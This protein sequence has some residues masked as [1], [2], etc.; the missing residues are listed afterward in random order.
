MRRRLAFF[1][2]VAGIV[3]LAGPA[4]SGGL[5]TCRLKYDLKGWS[6]IYRTSK[7]SG[8]ITCENGQSSKV[9][10]STRRVRWRPQAVREFIE[11]REES[12]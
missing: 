4:S 7:G 9:R 2:A 5:M 12:P 1:L 11:Q 8:K 10:I 6:V 3:L